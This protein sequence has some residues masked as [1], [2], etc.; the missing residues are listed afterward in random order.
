MVKVFYILTLLLTTIQLTIAQEIPVPDNYTVIDTV[1]GGLD[2]DSIGEL[3]VSYNHNVKPN[4]KYLG[5]PRELIIYKLEKG[6]WTEWKKSGQALYDSEAGG[7][8]G[9]PLGL[10]EIRDGFLLIS[11]SGGSS[12]KWN[13]T[14]K[15]RFQDGEFYLV[16][17]ESLAGKPCQYWRDVDFDI[18]TGH[19]LVKKEYEDC[20]TE[21]QEIYKRE[22]EAFYERGLKISIQKRLEREIIITTPQYGHEI[23]ISIEIE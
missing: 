7:M 22:N 10:I 12:W 14:D 2:N 13:F 3:V 11:H 4:D 8:M 15:Y 19:M 17:Y 20:E 6:Q 23:Y 18:S 5:V 16:G 1:V 9:D 21:D